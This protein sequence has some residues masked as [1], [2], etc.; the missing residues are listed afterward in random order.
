MKRCEGCGWLV[1][2]DW[3]RGMRA[4]RCM[5]PEALWGPGRVVG[6]PWDRERGAAALVRPAWCPAL[7]V[8]ACAVPA[9]PEGELRE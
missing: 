3:P 6:N 7:S 2:E 5:H 1:W 9:P 8:T 4:A